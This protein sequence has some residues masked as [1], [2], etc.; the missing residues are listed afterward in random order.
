VDAGN[1]STNRHPGP[2]S[3]LM[4][5]KTVVGRKKRKGN[6]CR[7]V[8]WTDLENQNSPSGK[9]HSPRGAAAGDARKRT[10]KNSKLATAW[11]HNEGLQFVAKK[12]MAT[13]LSLIALLRGEAS[14]RKA[15]RKFS[16][17]GPGGILEQ[18]TKRVCERIL[19]AETSHCLGYEKGQSPGPED[20]K[21]KNPPE[22]HQ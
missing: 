12:K 20:K 7:A 18:L 2:A 14:L 6:G 8:Y 22:R 5:T 1:T 17:P 11:Q 15:S 19:G 16:R 13:N 3:D 4:P 10:V 9:I 21:H